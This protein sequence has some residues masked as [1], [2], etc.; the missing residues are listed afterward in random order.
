M[1]EPSVW[2]PL[3]EAIDV[4]EVGVGENDEAVVTD[5]VCQ[6]RVPPTGEAAIAVVCAG[7]HLNFCGL[8]C[9]PQF[10]ATPTATSTATCRDP[11]DL[12]GA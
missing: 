6:M 2:A 11:D 1:R 4:Y 5:P 10:A 7:R 8:P 9:V 12:P 3:G